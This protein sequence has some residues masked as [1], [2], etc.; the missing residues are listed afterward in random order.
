MCANED[1]IERK[2]D[3]LIERTVAEDIFAGGEEKLAKTAMSTLCTASA[4][5][6]LRI[7][8][9]FF[10][11]II[12]FTLKIW[13]QW[14]GGTLGAIAIT[15]CDHGIYFSCIDR[16]IFSFFSYFLPFFFFSFCSLFLLHLITA[17]FFIS[18]GVH[19]VKCARAMGHYRG[20]N[21]P[22]HL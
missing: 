7:L 18:H 19:F 15:D 4:I 1:S 8:I 13:F 17:I 6:R 22:R 3:Y 10:F 16:H 21:I 2:L 5:E 9:T 14:S 12:D 11:R 20:C